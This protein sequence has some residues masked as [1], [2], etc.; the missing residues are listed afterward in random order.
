MFVGHLIS[1]DGQPVRSMLLARFYSTDGDDVADRYFLQ[2]SCFDAGYFDQRHGVFLSGHSPIG[3]DTENAPADVV[4][5]GAERH[6]TRC[7]AEDSQNYTRFIELMYGGA[8]LKVDG[9]RA[10]LVS[11]TGPT[12]E[13]VRDIEPILVD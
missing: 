13:L 10:Q 2:S 8:T 4:R 9:D 7:P 1:F 5:E 12:A 11:K 6:K 3:T